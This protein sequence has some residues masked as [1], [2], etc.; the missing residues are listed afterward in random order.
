M[1]DFNS[2]GNVKKKEARRRA[3]DKDLVRDAKFP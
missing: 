1:R 3:V 2:I